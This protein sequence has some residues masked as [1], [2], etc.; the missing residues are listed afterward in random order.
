MFPESQPPFCLR[1]APQIQ[2]WVLCWYCSPP[3]PPPEVSTRQNKQAALWVKR[4]RTLPLLEQLSLSDSVING[5]NKSQ[6]PPSIFKSKQENKKSNQ[7]LAQVCS[8]NTHTAS[9]WHQR[10]NHKV[11][12][13]V[14][15]QSPEITPLQVPLLSPHIPSLE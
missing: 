6:R 10:K 3:L 5:K 4:H 1:D 13:S 9:Q 8:L 11:Q 7:P 14:M 2:W 15:P 12:L